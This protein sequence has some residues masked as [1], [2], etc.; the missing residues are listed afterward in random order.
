MQKDQNEAIELI[1]KYDDFLV[2]SHIDPDGDSVGSQLA[3]AYVLKRLGKKVKVGSEDGIPDTYS[4]LVDGI[5]IETRIEQGASVAVVVD[6]GSLERVGRLR[7]AVEAS[8]KI[9]NIDH[10]KTNVRFGDVN[11]VDTSAGATA[12]ILFD[13]IHQMDLPLTRMEAECLLAAIMTD[14]GCF[15]FPTTTPKTMRIGAQL[16]EAGANPY[17]VATEI[18]W[19]RSPA[20][21]KLLGGALS[22]IEVDCD[23]RIATME[24]TR[25]MYEESGANNRDTEGFANYPRSIKGV[26]VGILLRE[27]DHGMFR[28][29]LR[30]KEGYD[31]DRVA[32][33][34]GGGGHPTAAGFR[35]QGDLETV[36]RKVRDEVVR[37]ILKQSSMEEA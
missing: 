29:S 27:V 37:R 1:D 18:F 35:I 34:L 23:G 20:G 15:R 30:S 36:K 9:L 17:R 14:T 16:I 12:E 11:L 4:F 28:V 21:I 6:C 26:V 19:S 22:T 3:I 33:A 25:R 13:L 32:S 8:S 24:V 7:P 10:H 31:V 5:E 2:T